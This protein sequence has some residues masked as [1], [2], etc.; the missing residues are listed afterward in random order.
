MA[1]LQPLPLLAACIRDSQAMPQAR[2]VSGEGL[3]VTPFVQ[4]RTCNVAFAQRD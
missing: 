3:S 1:Q 4:K 2:P